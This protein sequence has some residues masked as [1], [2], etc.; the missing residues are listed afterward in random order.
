[1]RHLTE[2]G[3]RWRYGARADDPEIR[4]R[5]THELRIIHDMGFDIYFLIVWD[6]CM[7]AQRR[8]IW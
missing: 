3:L 1:L 4:A 5:M 6:L 8:G 2:E 7:Y